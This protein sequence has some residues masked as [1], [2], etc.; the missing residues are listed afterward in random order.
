MWWW[1]EVARAS[2]VEIRV[3]DPAVTEVVMTC[4]DGTF[5]L[6]VVEGLVSWE[7][8]PKSCAVSM[9]RKSG[10][11]DAP[12]QWTCTADTCLLTEV[13]HAAVSDAPGR[14]NVITTTELPKGEAI[15][16][17]CGNGF[18]QRVTV[19]QNTVTFDGVPENLDCE[20][21][22]K[23]A[24]PAAFRPIRPGTWSCRLSGAMAV[25]VKT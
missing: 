13:A 8:T 6:P 24:L 23:G 10:R 2:A 15:E 20:I 11:V 5:H 18:R 22:Y 12:G 14:V 7:H 25:C 21:S 17:T 4:A 9:L 1:V 16:L 3:D 19:S